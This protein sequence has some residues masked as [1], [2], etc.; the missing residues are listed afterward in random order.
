LS[1]AYYV[2]VPPVVADPQQR[3]GWLQFGA[4][5]FD[6]GLATPA[7][8]LVQPKAGRLVLFPSMLWHGT[9]PFNDHEPRVTIAFDVVPS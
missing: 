3:Q 5:D 8:R 2:Q 6:L 4:P 9:M 1:S 7:Q